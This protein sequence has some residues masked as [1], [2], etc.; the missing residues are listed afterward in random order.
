MSTAEVPGTPSDNTTMVAVQEAFASAGY[1]G[2]LYARSGGV[3]L[4]GT[5]HQESAAGELPIG[6]QRRLE[7]SSDPDDQQLLV[8]ATCPR[9]GT[10]GVLT[11]HYGPGASPEDQDVEVALQR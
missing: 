9:C 7:G 11:L 4:C 8:G 1:E 2:A 6:L 5:C 10:K 3:V